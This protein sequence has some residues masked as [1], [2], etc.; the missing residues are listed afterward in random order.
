MAPCLTATFSKLCSS[1]LTITLYFPRETC[2]IF[3]NEG[4]VTHNQSIST[5]EDTL[6]NEAGRNNL[7]IASTGASSSMVIFAFT[8]MPRLPKYLGR[9][10]KHTVALTGVR[11]LGIAIVYAGN[12]ATTLVDTPR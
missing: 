6:T 4:V 3:A 9:T 5:K 2:C 7:A 8:N 12:L 11:G 1:H 10:V